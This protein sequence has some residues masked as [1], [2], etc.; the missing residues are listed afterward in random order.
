MSAFRMLSRQSVSA[1]LEETPALSPVET[2]VNAATF[3][4]FIR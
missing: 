1:E 4:A 2:I 3:T